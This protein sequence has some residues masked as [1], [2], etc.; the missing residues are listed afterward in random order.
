MGKLLDIEDN[1]VIAEIKKSL[2]AGSRGGRAEWLELLADRKCKTPAALLPDLTA[3]FKN[4][5][6]T[7]GERL[8][9]AAA[10]LPDSDA[11][12]YL[13][14]QCGTAD[15]WAGIRAARLLLAADSADEGARKFLL[16]I[17]TGA[18]PRGALE[19]EVLQYRAMASEALL[20]HG[21]EAMKKAAAETLVKELESKAPM[22]ALRAAKILGADRPEAAQWFKARLHAPDSIDIERNEAALAL[23]G[24]YEP[25]HA[26]A[27]K[28][29]HSDHAGLRVRAAQA[30]GIESRDA[31]DTML[32]LIVVPELGR[33]ARPEAAINS[34]LR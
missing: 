33:Y 5:G 23:A 7:F 20:R 18:P 31:T 4:P 27:V 21:T 19:V 3:A 24:R 14:A 26:A 15:P 34:M 30:L 6:L 17:L 22:A 32:R 11:H 28:L 13:T 9:C 1:T 12:K 8:Q 16:A 25:A 10:L 2:A 29:L